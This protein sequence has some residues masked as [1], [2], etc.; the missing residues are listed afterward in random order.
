MDTRLLETV[1]ASTASV[2]LHGGEDI[3]TF[4]SLLERNLVTGI[5]HTPSAGRTYAE[6]HG[7][8]PDGKALLALRK[9]AASATPPEGHSRGGVPTGSASSFSISPE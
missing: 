5:L 8:T 2:I 7:L 9:F 6:V 1:A 3:N 4:V